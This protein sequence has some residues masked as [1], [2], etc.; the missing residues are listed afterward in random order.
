MPFPASLE[1][2]ME[3]VVF[4]ADAEV[5]PAPLTPVVLPP[6]TAIVCPGAVPSVQGAHIVVL[7]AVPV[8]LGEFEF[9]D[10]AEALADLVV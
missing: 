6:A 7:A 2:T 4:E 10:I 9:V 5:A 8:C 3:G 1:R